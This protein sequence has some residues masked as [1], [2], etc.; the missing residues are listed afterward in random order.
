M[1][2]SSIWIGYDPREAEAFSVARESVR[3]QLNLPI[4]IRGVVLRT[5][6]DQHLYNRPTEQRAGR[7]W[8]VISDAPMSTE[9]AISRF[10]VPH[11]AGDRGWALFMDCDMLARTNLGRVIGLCDPTKAVM[12]VKHD[13]QPTNTAKMDGQIQTQYARKNWSSFMLFNLEHP[14]NK[15]LT[16]DFVNS[17]PGR[18]LHRFCWLQDDQIGELT[19]SWN[20]LVG[21]TDPSISPDVVHFTEGGPWMAGFES[22]PYADEWMAWR[23]RWAA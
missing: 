18:D 11:L 16:V 14:A 21:H 15:A 6:Q 10:L 2:L 17:V 4:P 5:L 3:R 12:C 19:S 1:L 9:F 23:N 13:H 20:F 8:D 22:V 7:L